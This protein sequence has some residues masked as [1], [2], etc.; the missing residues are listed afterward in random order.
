MPSLTVRQEL[1]AHD[2]AAGSEPGRHAAVSRRAKWACERMCPVPDMHVPIQPRSCPIGS[3][4]EI[5]AEITD[6]VRQ[7]LENRTIELASDTEMGDMAGWDS[8]NHIAI[9]VEAECR[10]DLVFD[11]VELD[12]ITTVGH[13]VRL[14]QSKRATINRSSH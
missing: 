4:A 1:P 8:M 12:A 2:P 13:L 7:V 5:L 6:V 10:F 3:D 11:L 9:L 14:I